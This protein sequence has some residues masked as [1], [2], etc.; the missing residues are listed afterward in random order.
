MEILRGELSRLLYEGTR[1]DTEYVFGD[2]ITALDD[3]PDG[4]TVALRAIAPTA[5]S[6]SW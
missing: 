1:D 6:T 5:R 3:R 2:Q 4:V